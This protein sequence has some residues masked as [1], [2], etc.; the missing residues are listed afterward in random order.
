MKFSST[1][2]PLFVI[3]LF[4]S[5]EKEQIAYRG[6]AD[7]IPKPQLIEWG[8]GAFNLNLK[9][10]LISL[11]DESWQQPLQFLNERLE[12]AANCRLNIG[13]DPKTRNAIVFTKDPL[14]REEEGYRVTIN[15]SRIEVAAKTPAGAFYGVQTLIQMMPPEIFL[16]NAYSDLSFDLP[17]MNIVDAPRFPY[18]GMHLDV[19]RHF[20]SVKE[21][22]RYI[23]L[24]AMHKFN[25]FHWHLTEDQGWRIEIKKYPRLTEVAAYR[26]E[27]LIGHYNDQPHKFDGKR[28][29]GFYTQAQ[30]KEIVK[31]ASDRYITVIP[32]IELPGHAQAAI[33]AY[34][35]LGCLQDTVLQV[36]TKWGISE[37]VY[38]PTEETFEFLENVLTEVID[39]FPSE[40]IHIGGDE[41]P[42]TQ[43]K[44]SEFVQN[45]MVEKRLKDE[46][47]VQSYFIKRI[48]KFLNSKNKKLIGWDEILEGGLAPN[49]TVM[50]WRGTEG[51]IA[52]AKAGHDVI[53]TPTSHC[54]F[55]YYQSQNEAEPLA[56]G[57][58][59]P[60]EKVYNY[61]PIPKGLNKRQ[62]KRI[63]G[64]QGNLWTE[65]IASS[66]KLDYMAY[67]RTCAM[68]EL[69]WT[70]PKFKKFPDFVKRLE[71]HLQRLSNY[72]VNFS[73]NI[74]D[75]AGEFEMKED[76]LFLA[77]NSNTPGAEIKYSVGRPKGKGPFETYTNPIPVSGYDKIWAQQFLDG[78]PK[79]R[80]FYTEI[81]W[82]KGAGK[83]IKLKH[84][85]AKQYQGSGAAGLLNGIMGSNARYGDKE[86]LGFDGKN[87]EA[88]IDLGEKTEVSKINM[89]F[90]KGEGQWIY[91][92]KAVE[93]F[94]SENGKKYESV[95]KLDSI[96]TN[97]KIASPVIPLNIETQYLKIVAERFGKIPDGSQG[98]GHEA[99]LFV[100]EI[101]LE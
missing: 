81:N 57:G 3:I 45:L 53:M 2:L 49:A 99:W 101:T 34:P 17:V 43:W 5:C 60:L 91:L 90:F 27:T 78:V 94:A 89:R 97:K 74:Y 88:T 72:G 77:L 55:D 62:R 69:N 66:N 65:Y 20:F 54:Y 39:L 16:E 15:P 42:K 93:V 38:C 10:T 50:S 37:N 6:N 56:I 59:L 73:E 76:T 95:G 30:V 4:A 29:G 24:L 67:P 14:I 26:N 100:D 58:Y 28:Y 79:G 44:E 1:F 19:C 98:A 71:T 87:F 82:H 83:S 40:Y 7:I 47:A 35:E 41:C 92:P 21:V 31:Y 84:Q 63:L 68:A 23:D 48:E 11:E 32:E 33:T 70:S 22:K 36:L 61:E 46:H 86:W 64:A 18:R 52:A 80:D 85:P 51:G 13:S 9:T 25:R 8:S 12:Y 75:V 96:S